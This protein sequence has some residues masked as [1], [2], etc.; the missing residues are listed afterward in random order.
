MES[1]VGRTKTKETNKGEGRKEKEQI[2]EREGVK[3][4]KRNEGKEERRKTERKR[5]KSL[6]PI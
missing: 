1:S 3:G 5:R 6:M 2:G 4:K